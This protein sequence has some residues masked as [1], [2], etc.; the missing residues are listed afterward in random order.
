MET[1]ELLRF[2]STSVS[3][4]TAQRIRMAKLLLC[5]LIVRGDLDSGQSLPGI[6]E[7]AKGL[8]ISQNSAALLVRELCAMG[9]LD[10]IQGQGTFV[11]FS[12]EVREEAMEHVGL[13]IIEQLRES[14]TLA[15]Y[16]GLSAPSFDFLVE[17]AFKERRVAS[18]KN[19]LEAARK[20]LLGAG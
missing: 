17:R 7:L 18:R 20:A 8:S 19:D 16:A 3:G 15:R 14:A 12:R 11:D 1:D 5:A 9:V 10:S 4:T 6:R 2:L 13:H